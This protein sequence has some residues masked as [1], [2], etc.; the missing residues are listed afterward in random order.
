MCLDDVVLLQNFN[1][2]FRVI[3]LVTLEFVDHKN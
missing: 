2:D 1:L 3:L